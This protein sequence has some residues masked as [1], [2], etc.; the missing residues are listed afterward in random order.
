MI[1]NSIGFCVLL[2]GLLSLSLQRFYSSIPLRELKRLAAQ[3]D[4]TAQRLYRVAAY[5]KSARL[6]LWLVLTVCLTTGSLLVA[7]HTPWYAAVSLLFV[8]YVVALVWLPSMQLTQRNVHVA[9]F[10]SP[11]VSWILLHTHRLLDPI[12]G[13]IAGRRSLSAHSRMYQ[14]DDL[15]E[16]LERQKTQVGNRINLNELELAKR[17]LVFADKRAAD[18]VQPRTK[19][20]IINADEAIGPVLL[21]RLHKQ[22]QDSFLVYKDSRDNIIGTL[23][24][25]DALHAK[26]GGRVFDLVR[27]DLT[28]VAEDAPLPEVLGALQK[29]VHQ[30]VVVR[31]SFDEFVGIITLHMVLQEIFAEQKELEQA[32][33]AALGLIP[34]KQQEQ[35]ESTASSSESQDQTAQPAE[36]AASQESSSPEATEVV[37]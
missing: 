4:A 28:Y 22:K 13:L 27:S 3:G 21:D 12:A 9:A 29:S 7:T 19:S 32:E 11:A 10:C 14:K 25:S 34:V 5:G 16:L 36:S 31:N 24:L 26:H 33:E 17:A 1:Q 18:I 35:N 6:L 8:L 20:H 2:L 37:E 23:A 30:L 15:L